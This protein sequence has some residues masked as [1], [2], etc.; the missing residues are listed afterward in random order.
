MAAAWGPLRFVSGLYSLFRC[1]NFAGHFIYLSLQ[2][3]VSLVIYDCAGAPSLLDKV[4]QK[5]KKLGDIH[6]HVH[7]YSTSENVPF[8]FSK[9]RST[10]K[11]ELLEHFKRTFLRSRAC[12]L[13]YTPVHPIMF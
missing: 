1:H 6:A 5:K 11:R 9:S 12:G 4:P 13:V 8:I 7:T 2:N 3:L 10:R